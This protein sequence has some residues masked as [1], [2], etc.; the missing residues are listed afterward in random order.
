MNIKGL[1][2]GVLLAVLILTA[3]G[4]AEVPVSSSFFTL[5]GQVTDAG[6]PVNGATVSLTINGVT[7][8]TL[9]A[10]N[11][12]GIGGY[13]LFELASFPD[14]IA[15]TS[16]TLTATSPLGKIASSTTPRAA[17][18]PQRIDLALGTSGIRLGVDVPARSTV[19]NVYAIYTITV[20][21]PG[22]EKEE[23]NL[24]IQ[25]PQNAQ[26]SL[27]THSITVDPGMSGNV[28]LYVMSGKPGSYDVGVTASYLTETKTITTTTT[29]YPRGGKIT[30]LGSIP[31]A[32]F[33]VSASYPTKSGTAQGFVTYVDNNASLNITGVRINAVGTSLDKKKG[34]ITGLA[35]VN[36]EGP[37]YFEVY[38]EDNGEPGTGKDVFRMDLYPYSK[39]AVL[40]S[41]NI[42][43]K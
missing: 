32:S 22:T 33:N 38:V 35:Q 28:L 23:Y 31:N 40:I 9:T 16:M 27:S 29:V 30:G 19:V 2:A 39:G 5:Y 43:I 36:G 6:V 26:A 12:N 42:Q 13:Y 1:T 4:T 24:A 8:T 7:Q 14:V 34:V 3:T 21:N 37:Y 20:V 41:G 25:N 17:V 18:E 15:G 11:I 10:S